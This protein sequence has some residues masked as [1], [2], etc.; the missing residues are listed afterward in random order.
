MNNNHKFKN[1]NTHFFIYIN[2]IELKNNSNG[3]N[4]DNI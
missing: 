3:K 4:I 1:K 2:S